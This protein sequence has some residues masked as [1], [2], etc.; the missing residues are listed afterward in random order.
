MAGTLS[1]ILLNAH[2]FQFLPH[3]GCLILS[4]SQFYTKVQAV[5]KIRFA[6]RMFKSGSKSLTKGKPKSSV[7]IV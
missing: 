3:C 4:S 1:C 6:S 2:F 5:L 7:A